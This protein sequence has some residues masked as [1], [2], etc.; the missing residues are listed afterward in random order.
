[1]KL[2]MKILLWILLFIAVVLVLFFGNKVEMGN[3]VKPPV[4]SIHVDGPDAFLTESELILSLKTQQPY[5]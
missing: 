4:V 1:M 2:W 3:V 5:L